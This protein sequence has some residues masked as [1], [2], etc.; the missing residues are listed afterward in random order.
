MR[1]NKLKRPRIY[2]GQNLV[3]YPSRKVKKIMYFVKKGDT[4]QS[5]SKQYEVKDKNLRIA[6]GLKK[7]SLLRPGTNILIYKM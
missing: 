1:W 3:I 4:L 5:I 2:A 7:K 6:N